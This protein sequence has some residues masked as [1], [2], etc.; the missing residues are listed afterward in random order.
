[1]IKQRDVYAV[2]LAGGLG[3]RFWPLS[4]ESCPKQFLPIFGGRS[5]FQE[6]LLRIKDQARP[7]NILIITNKHYAGRIRQQLGALKLSGCR[8]LL[9]PEGK[10][11]AAAI[12]WAAMEIHDR[13]PEARML[14]FPSDHFI[15]NRRSFARGIKQALELAGDGY[16]VTFGI[17]PTRPETGY[18][19]LK[20]RKSQ[21]EGKALWLVEEFIEKPIKK[22]AEEFFR[23]KNYFWNSGMFA[24]KA[25]VILKEFQRHLPALYGA[26]RRGLNGRSVAKVWTGLPCLSVDYGILEKTDRIAAI[27]SEDLGWSDLGSWE[28][29]IQFSTKD[30]N[31]NIVKGNVLSVDT[32]NSLVWGQKRMVAAIG[33]QDMVVVDTDDAL[34]VCRADSAQRVRDIVAMLKGGKRKSGKVL[35]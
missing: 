19:Y 21:Q 27:P 3:T 7:G 29:L 16:L 6:T 22:R 5:L 15:S 25:E 26:L 31:G 23:R 8:L 14:V 20:V 33:L 13:D 24:W 11:T 12:C 30:K 4:R 18:G 28:A 35:Y 1:M 32:Q 2:V 17:R 34:L 9:E 10:N